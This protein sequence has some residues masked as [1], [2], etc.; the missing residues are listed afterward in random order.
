M[1]NCNFYRFVFTCFMFR[2]Y[3]SH[4]TLRLMDK[5]VWGYN[6]K[7]KINGGLERFFNAEEII[8]TLGAV[9]RRTWLAFNKRVGSIVVHNIDILNKIYYVFRKPAASAVHSL[10][11]S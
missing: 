4:W 5:H 6:G 7:L 11:L 2:E 8:R 10:L 9:T 1:Q 3:S